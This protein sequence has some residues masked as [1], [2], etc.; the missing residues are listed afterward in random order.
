MMDTDTI[1]IGILFI[2]ALITEH[3]INKDYK[4]YLR[5]KLEEC[6][7]TLEF[8]VKLDFYLWALETDQIQLKNPPEDLYDQAIH[9]LQSSEIERLMVIHSK[10]KQEIT[11]FYTLMKDRLDMKKEEQQ[12]VLRKIYGNPKKRVEPK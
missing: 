6:D 3:K 10:S 4:S 11:Q 1:I 8:Y 9:Y 12:K 7:R 2:A 5:K